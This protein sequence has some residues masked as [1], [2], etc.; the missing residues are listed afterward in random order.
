MTEA[1]SE[2]NITEVLERVSSCG[3]VRRFRSRDFLR[4]VEGQAWRLKTATTPLL[5]RP[6]PTPTRQNS[7]DELLGHDDPQRDRLHGRRP[8]EVRPEI[9]AH[10][11][12]EIREFRST[13]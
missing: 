1:S 7:G 3:S 8:V 5:A 4:S 13:D 9:G 10:L 6:N 11:R 12:V 2:A